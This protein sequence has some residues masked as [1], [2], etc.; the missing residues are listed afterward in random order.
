[1]HEAAQPAKLAHPVSNRG[2][3]GRGGH[4]AAQRLDIGSIPGQGLACL[5]E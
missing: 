1:V 2:D 4:V 5:I 3:V